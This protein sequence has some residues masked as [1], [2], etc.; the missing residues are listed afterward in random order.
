MGSGPLGKESS[1]ET[2]GEGMS[3]LPPV[4]GIA[5]WVFECNVC[6]HRIKSCDA[7]GKDF[8]PYDPILHVTHDLL[9][10]HFCSRSCIDKFWELGVYKLEVPA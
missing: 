4:E 7:C 9:N 2:W 8:A 1:K 3:D 10:Y 5:E 6:Q